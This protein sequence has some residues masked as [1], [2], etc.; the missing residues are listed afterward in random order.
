MSWSRPRATLYSLVLAGA[1]KLGSAIAASTILPKRGFIV[2]EVF[3]NDPA[4]LGRT[5]GNTTIKHVE[6][7]RSSVAEDRAII[8]IIATP[9]SAAQEVADKMVDASIKVFLNYTD[10]L[11]RVPNGVDIHR[12]YPVTQLMH[13]LYYLTNVG[14]EGRRHVLP[15]KRRPD[16]LDEP[17][18][19]KTAMSMEGPER[20]VE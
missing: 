9:A 3:D 17:G 11:L 19:F 1:G 7:L 18:P 20:P 13:T 6:E 5:V 4:K 8:G 16:P 15:R 2:R 10:A 12:A 14:G